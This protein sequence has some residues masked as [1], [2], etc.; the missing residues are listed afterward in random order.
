MTDPKA[1]VVHYSA[2]P[3]NAFGDTAPGTSIRWLIDDDHDGAPVYSLR[4]IEVE[5]GGHTPRHTH[6]YEHENFVIEGAGR[7]WI[8]GGW[9]ALKPGDVVFVPGG[10]E[11]TYENTGETTFKFLCGIPVKRLMPEA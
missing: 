3:A 2:V 6:P 9:Q 4:M 7:V 1:K 8:N 5:P 11:H 10:M